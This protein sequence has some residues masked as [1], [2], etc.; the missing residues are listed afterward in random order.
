MEQRGLKVSQFQRRYN[1]DHYVYVENGSKNNSG[2]NLK[3]QNKVVPVYANADSG[4]RC[5][6]ALLDKYLSKLPP[7]AFEK[8]IFYMK[9]KTATPSDA[10]SPW[11]E[12]AP[13][14]KETLRTML[15]NMCE[16]A[17]VE[18]K[19]NHSLKATGATEM[20]AANVPEK[21]IQ[22]RTGHHS[23]EAL[24][25]YE[26]PPHEQHQ[27]VS[28]VLTSAVPQ[29]NFGDELTNIQSTA[30]PTSVV[31]M[32]EN[33]SL[34]K[35]TMV[36][37]QCPPTWQMPSLFGSMNH[38][39]VNININMNATQSKKSVEEFDKLVTNVHFPY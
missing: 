14:G 31:S 23:L 17:G 27:A 11:Y 9:P 3:I 37:S 21:L 39:S 4:S 29:R 20:F 28:N 16:R 8:D 13:V 32:V 38:C 5:V 34:T 24:R 35:S 33:R 18:R 6:V 25:L 36:Q 19:S 7:V 10:D 12:G 22:S 30:E 2:A 26:R 15:A 1:P